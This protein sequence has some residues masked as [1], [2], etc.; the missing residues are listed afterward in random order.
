MLRSLS[1]WTIGASLLAGGLMLACSDKG[2]DP[3]PLKYNVY[4]GC[5]ERGVIYVLDADSLTVTDSLVGIGPTRSMALSPEGRWLYVQCQKDEGG[6][7]PFLKIDLRTKQEVAR[8]EEGLG[9]LLLLK[10]GTL[11]LAGLNRLY[12]ADPVTLAE[13]APLPDTLRPWRVAKPGTKL[14]VEVIYRNR[15]RLYDVDTGELTGEYVPHLLTGETLQISSTY[16]ILH[17]DERRLLLINESFQYALAWFLVGDMETGETLLQYPL[18]FAH[19]S[20]AISSDGAYAIVTDLGSWSLESP[21]ITADVFDLRT[22]QHL[23]RFRGRFGGT[24]GDGLKAATRALFVPEERRAI[25]APWSMLQTYGPLQVLDV[26]GLTL[27]QTLWSPFDS[28]G[29]GGLAVG[30]RP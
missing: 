12:F 16:T 19:G 1:R 24:G 28:V 11:L 17:Q 23:R 22:K 30:P 4:V 26:E 6:V 3:K 21:P 9:N 15:F 10:G 2:T 20:I 5:D 14:P 29:I 13:V 7:G 25:L 8:V 27:E 18:A